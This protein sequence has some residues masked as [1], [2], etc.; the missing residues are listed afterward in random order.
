[1]VTRWREHVTPEKEEQGSG[2]MRFHVEKNGE[3]GESSVS[4]FL[5]ERRALRYERSMFEF[6]PNPNAFS[7]MNYCM[8][9][10]GCF[11][12]QTLDKGNHSKILRVW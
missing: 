9:K 2:A 1:M 6:G 3:V 8:M 10:L 7:L 4:V 11:S 12:K 5:I